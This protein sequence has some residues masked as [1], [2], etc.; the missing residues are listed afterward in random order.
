MSSCCGD[1]HESNTTDEKEE[2]EPTGML[3]KFLWKL[4]KA[5]AQKKQ[6]SSHEHKGC[7]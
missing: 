6:D 1:S 3:K 4:G 5:D 7:C 2:K